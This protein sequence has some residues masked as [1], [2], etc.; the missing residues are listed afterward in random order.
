MHLSL[1]YNVFER[2]LL[3]MTNEN[4]TIKEFVT[5]VV[6]EYL[7]EAQKR[8]FGL[9]IN[10]KEELCEELESAVREMT[11]KKIYGS[12]SVSEYRKKRQLKY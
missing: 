5:Q 3:R 9:N 1:L 11:L 7:N 6:D 2:N 10:F 12:L 4:P 8:G